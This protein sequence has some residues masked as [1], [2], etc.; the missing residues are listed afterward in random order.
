MRKTVLFAIAFAGVLYSQP[1]IAGQGGDSH[2]SPGIA[3][4]HTTVLT[5]AEP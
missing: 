3:A 2:V 4:S 5:S 1:A